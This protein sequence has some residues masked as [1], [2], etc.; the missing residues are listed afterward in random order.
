M[1]PII[2]G[3]NMSS[4]FKVGQQASAIDIHVLEVVY[5]NTRNMIDY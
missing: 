1:V 5:S 2:S 3:K 4:D